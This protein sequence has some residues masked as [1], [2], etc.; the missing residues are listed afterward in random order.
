M[1]N[2]NG[3]VGY[4]SDEMV[5]DSSE[6]DSGESGMCASTGIKGANTFFSK[7]A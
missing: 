6:N 5:W 2:T 3:W 1:D 7:K 4:M